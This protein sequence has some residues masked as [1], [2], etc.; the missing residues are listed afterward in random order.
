MQQQQQ[1]N[2]SCILDLIRKT[3]KF[4]KDHH[5]IFWGKTN[6]FWVDKIYLLKEC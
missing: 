4:I 2:I 6:L 1:Q 3:I 5:R